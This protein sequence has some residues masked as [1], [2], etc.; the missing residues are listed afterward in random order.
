M[1]NGGPQGPPFLFGCL[2]RVNFQS[3]IHSTL[4][5]LTD[6]RHVVVQAVGSGADPE[7]MDWL[8]AG[9]VAIVFQTR[10]YLLDDTDQRLQAR[11]ASE[12]WGKRF[13]AARHA[14]GT[15]G[16]RFYQPKWISSHY[17]LLDLRALELDPRNEQVRQS[18][19]KIASEEKRPDGGIGPARSI[20]VSDVCV[21][22][23]FLNYAS[24][25]QTN[26]TDLQSIVDFILA[27]RMDDGGFN[28]LRN[29][30][31]A[32]HSSLHSSLSVAE[33]I[34]QYAVSGYAYRLPE[35]AEAAASAREFMLR[36]RLFRSQR[37]GEI[38]SPQM[39]RLVY[40]PRWKFNILRALD[41]FRAAGQPWD[42]RM[43]DALAI[44]ASKKQPNGRWLLP[45]GHP[46]QV[47]FQMEK[48]GQPSRWNTLL[49]LRVLRRFGAEMDAT[50][51][52]IRQ[53]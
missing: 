19:A 16:Q 28:C 35:L 29:T 4:H 2:I 43:S 51:R 30:S 15:W 38:I 52:M 49:A 23:M 34:Q 36:H 13:L 46:G 18:I 14:D 48:V 21:N 25:F 24:Y 20:P 45:A 42:P 31:G 40:P 50:A 6:W 44:V 8:L 26:D 33:G 37:T 9:D 3:R 12:G 39:L 27:Q 10:R 5:R 1:K 41:H 7:V 17:T 53:D 32:Q 22:G 47:H 11:I